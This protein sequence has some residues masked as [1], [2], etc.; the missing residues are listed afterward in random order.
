[1]NITISQ[2]KAARALLGWTQDLLAEA[3]SLSKP[4]LANIERGMANPRQSTLAAIQTALESAGIEFTDGPGLRL[5]HDR[6]D[7][8][9]FRGH[10]AIDRLWDD[11]YT[12]LQMGE[13]RLISGVDENKFKKSTQ[14]RFD[15]MMKRYEDKGITGRIL[16]LTGDRNFA[17]PTSSYRWIQ[18]DRFLDIAYYVYADKYATL[19]WEPS[20]RVVMI[21][22]T[23]MADNYRAQ[24]NRHWDMAEVPLM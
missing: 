17:D 21:H 14:D 8:Q 9:V 24:F 15:S 19:L 4:A 10:D 18:K 3:A 12:T 7:V 23:V 5:A 20:P 6:L 2:I 13:E 22:N 11:I 16:S 1:M